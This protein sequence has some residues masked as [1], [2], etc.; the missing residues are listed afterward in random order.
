MR[1]NLISRM[2]PKKKYVSTISTSSIQNNKRHSL[3][4]SGKIRKRT[5]L[6]EKFEYAEKLK[7]KRN[8]ILFVSGI[9]HEKKEIEEIEDIPPETEPKQEIIEQKQIIDN[10]Q[11]HETKNLKRP[12]QKITSITHH[13]RLSSPFE[14]TTLKKYSSYITE[15]SMK[16]Y[17]TTTTVVNSRVNTVN[18]FGRGRIYNS[19]TSKPRSIQSS[20]VYDS[21]RPKKNTVMQEIQSRTITTRSKIGQPTISI[22][23]YNR[24]IVNQPRKLVK[25]VKRYVNS[26]KIGTGIERNYTEE[27][28]NK[29]SRRSGSEQKIRHVGDSQTK[30]ETTQDGDY[31]IKVTTIRKQI[32]R[33]E[34]ERPKENKMVQKIYREF[35]PSGPGFMPRGPVFIPHGPGFMPHG[36]RFVPHGPGFI[37]HGPGFMPHGPRYVPHGPGFMPPGPRYVPH[38]PGFMPPGPRFVPHG[39]GF[40]PHGPRFMSKIER[41][42]GPNIEYHQNMPSDMDIKRHKLSS[43]YERHF[44]SETFQ[45]KRNNKFNERTFQTKVT[46]E[47]KNIGGNQPIAKEMKITTTRYHRVPRKDL[48]CQNTI[49]LTENNLQSNISGLTQSRYK[50]LSPPPRG[51]ENYRY[52]ESKHVVKTGRRNKP[53]TIHHRRSEENFQSQIAGKTSSYTNYTMSDRRK[54]GL[55]QPV[56]DRRQVTRINDYTNMRNCECKEK[57]M[58]KKYECKGKDMMKKYERKGKEMMKKYECKGKDMM[59]K[60]ERKKKGEYKG[61]EKCECK[62]MGICECKGMEKCE[63]KGMEKCECKE[64]EI[65]NENLI[66]NQIEQNLQINSNE[67]E[68]IEQ[69]KEEI[70]NHKCKEEC[71]YIILNCP[72]HGKQTVMRKKYVQ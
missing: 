51:G 70:M 45:P 10:Y 55:S 46:Y 69:Q 35:E 8:Y 47:R 71:A 39:P 6:G 19:L 58:F 72:I 68:N 1:K 7:E 34:E 24:T 54:V 59:K 49:F 25:E 13:E 40:M 66:E 37:P 21:Y 16:H 15:P 31:L 38:G 60:Y 12:K 52:F 20:K 22:E 14:R 36:P 29:Y 42:Q 23:K 17:K 50:N 48:E 30:T 3:R 5:V 27:R 43:S 44:Q 65:S 62:G 33:G 64:N 18:D 2:E 4:G 9:G 53:I 32:K 61:M 41:I 57:Q 63:C 26:S 67:Q 11:Y 56:N 28:E